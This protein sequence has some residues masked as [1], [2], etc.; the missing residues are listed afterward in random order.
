MM[1]PLMTGPLMVQDLIF[2]FDGVIADTRDLLFDLFKDHAPDMS[3]EEFD[4]HFD[5]NVYEAPTIR[6]THQ[7]ATRLHAAYCERLH[8]DHLAAARPS[9]RRLSAK[10]RMFIVSSGDERGITRVLQEANLRSYFTAVL[11]HNTHRS[12]V[13]KLH[14]IAK[15]FGVDLSQAIFITDTL[16]DVHEARTTG[17]C[18]IAETFGFHTRVRLE[19]GAPHAIVDS[20]VEI[21]EAIVRF[22]PA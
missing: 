4:A 20:W 5:G 9:L 8:R 18:V 13:T 11:G 22:C 1:E 3:D 2:D 15:D 21:E 10:H 14:M 19:R 12:K 6:F 16:G 7:A 17:T